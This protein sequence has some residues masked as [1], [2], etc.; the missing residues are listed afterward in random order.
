MFFGGCFG[1]SFP[2]HGK[3]SV[4]ASAAA[5]LRAA[6]QLGLDALAVIDGEGEPAGVLFLCA[7]EAVEALLEHAPLPQAAERG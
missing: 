5:A 6:R 2:P 4:H 3:V 1:G 7:P